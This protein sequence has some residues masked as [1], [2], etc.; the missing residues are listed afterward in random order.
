MFSIPPRKNHAHSSKMNS[1]EELVTWAK[2]MGVKINGIKP[3]TLGNRTRFVATKDLKVTH[4][5][6]LIFDAFP[7]TTSILTRLPGERNCS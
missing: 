2:E 6:L 1:L 5:Q 7:P 4:T 3:E